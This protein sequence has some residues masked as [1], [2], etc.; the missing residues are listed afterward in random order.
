MAHA[1]QEH[2]TPVT[3]GPAENFTLEQLEEIVK[4]E[5]LSPL[6]VARAN[7]A[8]ELRTPIEPYLWRWKHVRHRMTQ[9]G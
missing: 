4:G 6:W 2:S 1:I 8:T 3:D 9:I 7:R 5:H